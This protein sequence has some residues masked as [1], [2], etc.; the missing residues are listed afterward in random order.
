ML[1]ILELIFK[2]G[3]IPYKRLSNAELVVSTQILFKNSNFPIDGEFS[4]LQPMQNQKDCLC[5]NEFG[6]IHFYQCSET[7]VETI[8]YA[9]EEFEI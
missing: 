3:D 9:D 5:V 7:R 8:I 2:T 6:C 4:S 1:D